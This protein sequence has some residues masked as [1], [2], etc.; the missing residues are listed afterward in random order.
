MQN[1]VWARGGGRGQTRAAGHLRAASAVVCL[2]LSLSWDQHG[3]QHRQCE[4]P[5]CCHYSHVWEEPKGVETESSAHACRRSPEHCIATTALVHGSAPHALQGREEG[6]LAA[7]GRPSCSIFKIR[8]QLQHIRSR[9]GGGSHKRRPVEHRG[10]AAMQ[11]ATR[12]AREGGGSPQLQG[13]NHTPSAVQDAG[14]GER[15]QAAHLLHFAPPA[16]HHP[17]LLTAAPN[18]QRPTSRALRCLACNDAPMRGTYHCALHCTRGARNAFRHAQSNAF[19]CRARQTVTVLPELAQRAG[20]PGGG[21]AGSPQFPHTVGQ[22]PLS[23]PETSGPT[24]I[25]PN[26]ARK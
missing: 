13:S 7:A 8:F 21:A 1:E 19:R 17:Y 16:P 23:R 6:A 4:Q 14:L 26:R 12:V 25:L 10:W 11:H 20:Q 2:Q 15:S 18:L 5:S 9:G 24:P 3:E 22:A